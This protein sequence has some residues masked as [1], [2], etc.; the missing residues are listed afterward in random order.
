MLIL[1][2][3]PGI[4]PLPDIVVVWPGPEEHRIRSDGIPCSSSE[5]G[6]RH[7]VLINAWSFGQQL[8]HERMLPVCIPTELEIGHNDRLFTS[9]S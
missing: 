9:G 5:L 1:H 4:S 7:G 3:E 6:Y 2:K 8:P